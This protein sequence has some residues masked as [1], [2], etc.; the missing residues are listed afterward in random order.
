MQDYLKA[1]LKI[2]Q[3]YL[4]AINQVFEIEKKAKLIKEE[5]SLERNLNKLKDFFEKELFQGGIRG[6]TG[7]TGLSYHNPIGE[8]Y[9]ETR[10]DC[11]AS[12]AGAS[13][14]NLVI[15]EVIKPIVNYCYAENDIVVK[16]I[17]QKAVV[18]A[19]SKSED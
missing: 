12:I 17:V 13:S 9:S 1:T 2:P 8:L 18:I 14:E 3:T 5:H 19:E 6:T 7:T 10:T 11:E 4:D 15:V 16:S